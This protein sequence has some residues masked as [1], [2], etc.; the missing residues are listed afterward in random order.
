MIPKTS[1]G[2]WRWPTL[3]RIRAPSCVL[4]TCDSSRLMSTDQRESGAT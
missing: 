3:R 4:I 1:H 2:T